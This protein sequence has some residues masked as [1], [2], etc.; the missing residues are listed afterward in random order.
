MPKEWWA[1][2]DLKHIITLYDWFITGD[3]TLYDW[4]I[5]G[6]NTLYDWFITGDNTLYDWFINIEIH[7]MIGL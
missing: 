2:E 5:T 4:F 7:C 3:N 1:Y 6:D